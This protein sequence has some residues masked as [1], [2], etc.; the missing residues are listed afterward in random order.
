[1]REFQEL[2][3]L[4]QTFIDP[5]DEVSLLATLR[6]DFFGISDDELYQWKKSGGR[7]SIYHDDVPDRAEEKVAKALLK[8]KQYQKWVR[9]YSSTIAIGKIAE[10][11]GFH[12]LLIRNGRNK[13]VYKSFLQIIEALRKQEIAGKTSYKRVFEHFSEMVYKKTTVLN[14]EEDANAVRVMNVH[15]AKGLEAKIVFLAHP[16]KHVDPASFLSKHIKRE[17]HFSKGYFSFTVKKGFQSKDIALPK[18]WDIY[19][20][21]EL[22]YLNAEELRILYVAAT[23][24]QNALIISSSAKSDNKNPWSTLFEIENI[25]EFQLQNDVEEYTDHWEEVNEADFK[26]QTNDMLSWM[27]NRKGISFDYWSPTKDK[28]YTKVASIEREEGG[29]KNWGTI[30]HQ[31][32]EKV[33]KGEDVTNYTPFLLKQFDFPLEKE[34][35]VRQAIDA[36]IHS[37]FWPELV[38]AKHVLTEV[39]FSIKVTKDHPLYKWIDLSEGNGHPYIVKGVIDLI[40]KVDGVWKIVDYKTDNPSDPEHFKTLS[41]FYHDQ[42]SF[43][44]YTWEVMT[45]EKV[46]SE[47]LFF[48]MEKNY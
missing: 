28:D 1:M 31:V 21:E 23:R 13:Q 33:V 20:Q 45:G 37:D 36:L 41:D 38:F 18:D 32:F 24:P 10:D 14:I 40:Y 27:E 34:F 2:C 43:Y 39:P 25:E 35:E 7:F 26:S 42:I 46:D 16:A 3:I 5:T 47:K 4:L 8:L 44:K 9:Q 15:K 22:Q 6:G 30:I 12:L 48:V 29:G 17:D 11:S 19:K